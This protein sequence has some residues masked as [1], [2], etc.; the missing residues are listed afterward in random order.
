MKI[1]KDNIDI[2]DDVCIE[3]PDEIERDGRFWEPVGYGMGSIGEYLYTEGEE[4]K[5]LEE[6]YPFNRPI[7]REIPRPSAPWLIGNNKTASERPEVVKHGD[8]IYDH[9]Y[10]RAVRVSASAM[11]NGLIG[12]RRFILEEKVKVSLLP[13][14]WCGQ[15]PE[16]ENL[17]GSDCIL[18]I[19]NDCPVSPVKGWSVCVWNKRAT[20]IPK[21]AKEKDLPLCDKCG[22]ANTKTVNV[23][24]VCWDKICIKPV[25]EP[26]KEVH[27]SCEGCRTKELEE[28]AAPCIGCSEK[29]QEAKYI[30]RNWTPLPKE[31]PKPTNLCVDCTAEKCHFDE[32]Y[33]HDFDI[34]GCD[35]GFTPTKCPSC[36]ADMKTRKR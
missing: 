26:A 22:A 6:N 1:T 32:E 2:L 27:T 12:K 3:I 24:D 5:L 13:C 31:Q 29:V 16:I 17:G 30:R 36:G 33:R 23:C 7:L 19:N 8:L 11:P 34:Q 4:V 21:P 25:P 20:P 10:L 9:E 28:N 18:H 14:P 35:K 15:I